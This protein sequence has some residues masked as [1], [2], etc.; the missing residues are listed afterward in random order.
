MKITS[1]VIAFACFT[2]SASAAATGGKA[3][4]IWN[5]YREALKNDTAVLPLPGPSA[6]EKPVDMVWHLP[7][8]L[9]PN[10]DMTF[11]L[12]ASGERPENGR[13]LY[14]Y[15]HGSGPRDGEYAVGKQLTQ[16]WT[17]D[18]EAWFVPRIPN[19]GQYYRWWQKSKQYAWENLLRRVLASDE[20]DP[21]RIYIL[22]IS[23]GGYGSQRL[24]SFYADYFAA[25]GPMAGGEPLVNAPTDNLRNTPFSLLTGSKDTG[26]YRNLL[27]WRTGMALD[28]L[29]RN[30]P[31]DYEHQVALQPDRGHAIDYSPTAPWLRKHKRR[32][33][34]R[35][36]TWEDYEMDGRRRT[37]FANIEPITRPAD[38]TRIRYD[39]V[40]DS[41]A[42]SITLNVD[43]V[44]YRSTEVD[45]NWGIVLNSERTFRPVESGKVRI[46]LDSSMLNTDRKIS[47]TVNG[48]KLKA[49]KTK[50]SDA[51]LR[52]AIELWGDPRRLYEHAVEI[53]W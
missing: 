51:T 13:P 28:S 46:Y 24:A 38:D 50:R 19:E 1:L 15:T 43:T 30:N 22:G 52:R 11:S 29:S 45:P 31:G 4:K 41:A 23:E 7:D 3:F 2:V 5:E 40:V 39:L 32:V 12:L 10:A 47:M 44:V 16:R 27:T 26:F 9:E 53:S 35:H 14:I 42:N 37:A 34:P 48:K 8:S 6:F 17:A 18:G 36:V 20:Y 21:E 25:A 49:V 33:S